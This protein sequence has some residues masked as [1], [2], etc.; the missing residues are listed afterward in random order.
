MKRKIKSPSA[1]S[2]NIEYILPSKQVSVFS[3]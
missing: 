2:K 3:Q 1:D